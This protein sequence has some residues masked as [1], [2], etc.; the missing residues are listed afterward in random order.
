MIER[1]QKR[2]LAAAKITRTKHEKYRRRVQTR[3]AA[4]R[5]TAKR[6]RRRQCIRSF[7]KPSFSWGLNILF[8]IYLHF[9]EPFENFS[10]VF[11]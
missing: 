10:D 11:L 4:V 8:V 5:P 1:A 3:Y 2:T 6:L 7:H 9:C